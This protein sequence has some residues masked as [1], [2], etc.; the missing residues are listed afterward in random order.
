[1]AN[2]PLATLH[3]DFD[4]PEDMVFNRAKM[5]RAFVQIGQVHMRDARRLVMHRAASRAGE[6]PGFRTGKLARSIGYYV[7]RA[8]KRRS[9]L[10]VRIA[11]NQ[12]RG[13]GNRQIVG[14]FYPAFLFYGVRRGAVRRRKHHQG[15]SGGT[16]WRIAPR[17][18]FMAQVLNTRSPWTKY[19]L[20]RALRQSLRPPR[21]KRSS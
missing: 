3:I 11:P 2:Q 18:N 16:P 4:Q 1:M 17:N 6:N 12:K 10:M 20:S 15:A 8:S 14:D 19:I 5:R 7:P 21:K 9:G 13:E